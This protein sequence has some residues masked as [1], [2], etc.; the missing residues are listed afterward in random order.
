MED[1][2]FLKHDL[3][4]GGGSTYVYT[5]HSEGRAVVLNLCVMQPD[6]L[7]LVLPPFNPNH[8]QGKGDVTLLQ[9]LPADEGRQVPWG[10]FDLCCQD[11]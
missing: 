7:L 8:R 4:L 5:Q 11:I 3:C 1:F 6:L 10:K 9:L 2:W